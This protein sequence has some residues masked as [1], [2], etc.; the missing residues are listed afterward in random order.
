[1]PCFPEKLKYPEYH[2]EY[3]LGY[4]LGR[5]KSRGAKR[6][7]T[8]HCMG[9]EIADPSPMQWTV[10]SRAEVLEKA[11]EIIDGVHHHTTPQ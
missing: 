5:A 10:V 4:H 3:H 6:A 9:K 7:K 8:V 2:L 11:D 1:M